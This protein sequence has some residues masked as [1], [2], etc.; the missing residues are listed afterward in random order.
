MTVRRRLFES[1]FR[2]AP[3][4]GLSAL[5]LIAFAGLGV[6]AATDSVVHLSSRLARAIGAGLLVVFAADVVFSS[7]LLSR[8]EERAR[9]IGAPPP[10]PPVVR[11]WMIW[12]SLGFSLMLAVVYMAG[13]WGH[14]RL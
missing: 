11:M 2:V 12:V 5:G 8:R 3:G 10:D 9:R 1:Q 7:I 13:R 6:L 14:L 4:A